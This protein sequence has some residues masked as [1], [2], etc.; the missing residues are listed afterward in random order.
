MS[1]PRLA[2]AL[3]MHKADDITQKVEVDI[4]P[5]PRDLST[6]KEIVITLAVEPQ[7]SK[8]YR[9]IGKGIALIFG[10]GTGV[11]A[12][13]ALLSGGIFIIPALVLGSF[14]AFANY[15]M[16]N[17][18]VTIV[19]EEGIDGLFKKPKMEMVSPNLEN[20]EVSP[21]ISKKKQLLLKIGIFLSVMFG[22]TMAAL[23]YVAALQLVVFPIVASVAFILP[24]FGILLATLTFIC[25]TA[26]MSKGFSDLLKIDNPWQK[27][28][29]TCHEMFGPNAERDRGKS[30]FRIT[31]ERSVRAVLAT[32]FLLSTIALVMLGIANTL[33]TCAK[34]FIDILLT[35][36]NVSPAIATGMSFVIAQVF[37]MVA[38]IPFVLKVTSRP[39]I[40]L[41]SPGKAGS[42][43]SAEQKPLDKF[44][45]L[46]TA[47]LL[48]ACFLNSACMSAIAMEGK[49]I[50]T[51]ILIGGFGAF[52]NGFISSTVN[53]L[54]SSVEEEEIEQATMPPHPS[55]TLVIHSHLKTAP[56]LSLKVVDEHR[57]EKT[58]KIDLNTDNAASLTYEQPDASERRG[59]ALN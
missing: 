58:V 3:D 34:G 13:A 41:F 23:T 48:I 50:D 19:L 45:I 22:M 39:I 16:T 18:D 44:K 24:G 52:L 20:S 40:W 35:I 9:R 56:T 14:S 43:D 7:L 59:L 46:D 5:S 1:T 6:P 11:T 30:K 51:F 28:K 49:V 21:Y 4:N 25:Q 55:T 29:D 27:I 17:G 2:L 42:S 37:S 36:P 26:L 8:W 53:A 10:L 12:V 32:T 31:V 33:A 57:E 15:R 54:I 47:F 38:Q